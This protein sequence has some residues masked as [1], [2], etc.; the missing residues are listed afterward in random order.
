VFDTI[1]KQEAGIEASIV[2]TQPR[3]LTELFAKARWA[4][5]PEGCF[6][7]WETGVRELV[8]GQALPTFALCC[9]FAGLL[10][11]H[12]SGVVGNPGFE[13]LGP[14]SSGKTTLLRLVASVLGRPDERLK[15]WNTTANALELTMARCGGVLLLDE[16]G[17]FVSSQDPARAGAYRD[18]V[19]RLAEGSEKARW[20][21]PAAA[22]HRF[23]FL[24]STNVGLGEL[25]G[26]LTPDEV[27]AS[28]VRLVTIA[29]DGG[30]GLGVFD[31]LPSGVADGGEA[32]GR[33]RIL[34]D[35]DP[36]W[37]GGKF[38]RQL[39][40]W[41]STRAGR[42]RLHRCVEGARLRFRRWAGAEGSGGPDLRVVEGFALVAAAG[43]LAKRWGVLPLPS[44]GKAV[45]TVYGRRVR[46]SAAV[47]V[48]RSARES[49][50][51]Y[52]GRNRATLHDIS[53]GRYPELSNAELDRA[54]GFIRR[55]GAD[56][57]LLV[58]A[59]RWEKEFGSAAHRLLRELKRD[60]LLWTR[61]GLQSQERVRASR[62]KDRVY[63]I[64]VRHAP[65]LTRVGTIQS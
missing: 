39:E 45:L 19:M 21:A 42:A 38:V 62:P 16:V 65:A 25:L 40:Q 23:L 9:A 54:L 26:G 7:D 48:P 57:W 15:T 8:G 33:L 30:A 44:I 5:N 2:S 55:Q 37:A 27:T 32:V 59:A 64:L 31:R 60:G 20:G 4:S 3:S 41:L 24:S 14:S 10:L 52:V 53:G 50:A 63:R 61:E 12:V 29:A 46:V 17:L 18:A 13:F 1:A 35:R 58:R 34:A 49:V 51:A 11:P 36:G 56:T 43:L 47:T 22:A 6:G 28:Q